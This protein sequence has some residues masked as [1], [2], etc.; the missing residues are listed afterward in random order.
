MSN[1]VNYE[2]YHADL[3][4]AKLI[5]YKIALDA[6]QQNKAFTG[7]ALKDFLEKD[8]AQDQQLNELSIALMRL[9]KADHMS[10]AEFNQDTIKLPKFID[11]DTFE[12]KSFD[13]DMFNYLL[14]QQY[15]GIAQSIILE[16]I[17]RFEKIFFND[18][19]LIKIDL[20][21][22]VN[23]VIERVSKHVSPAQGVFDA[24]ITYGK[25]INALNR[26]IDYRGETDEIIDEAYVKYLLAPLEDLNKAKLNNN[27]VFG[28]LQ[29]NATIAALMDLI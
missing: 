16:T 17:T 3:S 13:N 25:I 1:N 9:V 24:M 11:L 8:D 6:I 5:A 14:T 21:I 12:P 22:I 23:E 28:H 4:D 7:K 19:K 10:D 2:T 15:Q 18:H 26:P 27:I 29:N 20:D